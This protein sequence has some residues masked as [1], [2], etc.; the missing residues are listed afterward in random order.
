[1]DNRSIVPRDLHR[2]QRKADRERR[3]E[4]LQFQEQNERNRHKRW[5]QRGGDPRSDQRNRQSSLGVKLHVGNLSYGKTNAVIVLLCLRYL[6]TLMLTPLQQQ[7]RMS[8]VSRVYFVVLVRFFMSIFHG[9][10]DTPS[11]LCA[12]QNKLN[13]PLVDF[14]ISG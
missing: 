13:L 14:A 4:E 6:S 12:Q 5:I 9:G 11:L 3:D 7:L 1:M 2:E 8:S 10:K